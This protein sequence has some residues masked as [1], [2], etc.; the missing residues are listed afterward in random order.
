MSPSLIEQQEQL[1]K[2]QEAEKEKIRQFRKQIKD[3]LND[4]IDDPNASKLELE[5]MPKTLRTIVYELVE[6]IELTAYSFGIEDVDRHCVVYKNYAI[7]SDEELAALRKGEQYDPEKAKLEKEKREEEE[8]ESEELRRKSR[9]KGQSTKD[10]YKEKYEHLI[11]KDAGVSAAQVTVPNA[12]FGFVPS[13]NKRDQRSIEQTL[14]DLK[15]KKR[16]KLE[17]T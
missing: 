10:K 7:P 12:K 5:P 11:G 13:E 9:L 17:S 15:A 8:K 6:E 1:K 2:I 16:A 4:F 3:R 14:A